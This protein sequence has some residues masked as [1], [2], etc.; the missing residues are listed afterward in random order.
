MS[1]EQNLFSAHIGLPSTKANKGRSSWNLK[2]R[3]NQCLSIKTIFY[4]SDSFAQ[5]GNKCATFKGPRLSDTTSSQ[6]PFSNNIQIWYPLA[7]PTITIKVHLRLFSLKGTCW[8]RTHWICSCWMWFWLEFCGMTSLTNSATD[9][10]IRGCLNFFLKYEYNCFLRLTLQV[11]DWRI[12]HVRDELH[13][14]SHLLHH[15]SVMTSVMVEGWDRQCWLEQHYCSVS[16][17]SNFFVVAGHC[18]LTLNWWAS[19]AFV[20]NQLCFS[21]SSFHFMDIN[22]WQI[23]YKWNW[24]KIG[25]KWMYSG[26]WKVTKFVGP[27]GTRW[28]NARVLMKHSER[29]RLIIPKYENQIASYWKK[30]QQKHWKGQKVVEKRA[31]NNGKKW[32]SGDNSNYLLSKSS[33]PLAKLERN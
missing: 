12:D 22:R 21:S 20:S 17:P 19:S 30:I 28:K 24:S 25:N 13:C 31:W 10:T 27:L 23:E 7:K 11:E 26:C 32:E 6:L 4:L 16:L 33:L 15:R 9:A 2:I 3:K 5:C 14:W 18:L 29:G 1:T 8:M